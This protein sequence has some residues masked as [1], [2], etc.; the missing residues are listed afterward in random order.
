MKQ[1]HR[2]QQQA[3]AI[4]VRRSPRKKQQKQLKSTKSDK[5]TFKQISQDKI[6]KQSRD[7]NG[8]RKP[9]VQPRKNLP[10]D[11]D[12]FGEDFNNSTGDDEGI[13]F[14]HSHIYLKNL[15]FRVLHLF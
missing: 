11:N 15:L 2:K 7:A 9:Y 4:P 6:A 10:D 14:F 5:K 3:S 1:Q 12:L 8:L 13:Y